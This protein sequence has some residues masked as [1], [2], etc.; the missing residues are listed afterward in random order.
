[1]FAAGCGGD[2]EQDRVKSYLNRA[3]DVQKRA[4]PAFTRADRAY[5]NFA[6]GKLTA[7][8]A[9]EQLAAAER[10]IRT[11]R[12]QLAA[13]RP[14]GKAAPLHARLLRY[15]DL[16][17]GLAHE[18]TGLAA[19]PVRSQGALTDLPVAQ[20][21]LQ[22]SLGKAKR[23]SV[24]A[25]AFGDYVDSLRGV[26]GKLRAIDAPPLLV[27]AH[28]EQVRRLSAARSLA[29]GLR[30][31]VLRKDAPAVARLL[32]RVRKLGTLQAVTRLPRSAL[33]GYEDRVK[34]VIAAEGAVRQE[35]ARL[36]RT[37]R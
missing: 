16:N 18:T 23:A 36:Q 6:T 34:A 19:Y 5:A 12:D 31:A 10:S 26:I 28:R 13:I 22:G 37:V 20:K 1:V 8:V 17:I 35:Q 2:S 14:P 33:R 27:A 24:Q 11:T 3:N 7:D 30:A 25:R 32:L 15:Y 29:A 9:P 21:R 4:Q